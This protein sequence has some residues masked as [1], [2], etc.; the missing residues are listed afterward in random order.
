MGKGE[1][2][3]S[4]RDNKIRHIGEGWKLKGTRGWGQRG[5]DFN[6]KNG[7]YKRHP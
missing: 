3:R 7:M 5:G 4:G 6:I 1:H 2:N